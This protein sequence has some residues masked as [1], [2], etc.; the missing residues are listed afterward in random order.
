MHRDHWLKQQIKSWT[1][2]ICK[3]LITK[4]SYFKIFL[5][6]CFIWLISQ[7]IFKITAIQS[8]LIDLE[9]QDHLKESNRIG[10][11]DGK[12]YGNTPIKIQS[13]VEA[14]TI[15]LNVETDV[16]D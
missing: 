9:E 2:N 11:P 15:D 3:N 1:S 12:S 4:V 6:F 10:S 7:I 14:I 16:L 13:T 8:K 5:G